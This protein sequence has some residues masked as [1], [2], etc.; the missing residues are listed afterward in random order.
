MNKWN[1]RYWSQIA[2]L[3]V[4]ILIIAGLAG[5]PAIAETATA[6]SGFVFFDRN[7]NGAQDADEPGLPGV[8]IALL[9]DIG[10][11]LTTSTASDGSYSFTG[12]TTGGYSISEE[13]LAGFISTTPD[14]VY[15][16]ARSADIIIHFGDTLLHTVTG[17]VFDDLDQDGTQ[18]LNEPGIEG[19]TIEIY[20]DVDGDGVVGVGE[21]LLGST[22][23]GAQGNYRVP[24]LFPG[25]RVLFIEVPADYHP[26]GNSGG[27]VGLDLISSEVGGNSTVV[28]LPVQRAESAV[29][30]LFGWV[31]HDADGDGRID[32]GEQGLSGVAVELVA[33][34]NG[35][36]RRD[37]DEPITGMIVS[38]RRGSVRLSD[39]NPGAYVAEVKTDSLPDGWLLSPDIVAQSLA[40]H[41]GSNEFALGYFSLADVSPWRIDGWRAETLHP[42]GGLYSAREL[43]D[44]TLRAEGRSQLFPAIGG[45]ALALAQPERSNEGKARQQ[46]AA[47]LMNL[48]SGRLFEQTPIHLPAWTATQN[49][50]EAAAE[51][52]SVLWPPFGF[53]PVSEYERVIR[54]AGALN[55]GDGIGR[56]RQAGGEENL[57]DAGACGG[58]R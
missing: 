1:S 46:Y 43:A 47:L 33:D 31:W 23:S 58:S 40:L 3:A 6:I 41:A 22:V 16:S 57:S 19:A 17:T 20:D 50:G 32:A 4:A 21:A 29:A 39:L 11:V 38:G 24:D 48:A 44:L 25:Q 18:A 27:E 30:S 55:Q 5:A 45:V 42:G 7:G 36:G 49:V 13:N 28:D 52:E 2:I 10:P 53:A 54:L 56:C 15:V 12:L 35:N 51:I 34:A 8:T 37:A 9:P 14:D 26:S